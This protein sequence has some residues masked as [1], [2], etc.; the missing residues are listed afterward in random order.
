MLSIEAKLTRLGITL[1]A[2]CAPAA[3]YANYV[4]ANELLFVAGKGPG[5]NPRGKLGLKYST[6]EGYRFARSAGIEVLAVL[7]EALGSL[8]RVKRVVKVQGFV[9]SDPEFSE[10]H[11]VLDGFSDLMAEIFGEKGVH[12]RSVL[13][14]NSLRDHLPVIVECIFEIFSE[15]GGDVPHANGHYSF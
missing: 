10:H 2:S 4:L 3:N 5:G 7:K 8:D 9:N 14:A 15:N 12:A 1:P 6:E 13:G 11:K